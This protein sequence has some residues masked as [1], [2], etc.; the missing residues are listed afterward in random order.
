MDEETLNAMVALGAIPEEQAML[1]KQQQMGYGLM[2][3]PSAEGRTVG[4]TYVAASPLEHLSV[5]LHKYMGAKRI[6]DA[7]QGY[8]NTLAQQTAGRSAYAR[9]LGRHFQQANQPPVLPDPVQSGPSLITEQDPGIPPLLRRP[10]WQ[11]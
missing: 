7:E 9:A 1:M 3:T 11:G 8:R 2:Q 5:A 4:H 10:D 6:K